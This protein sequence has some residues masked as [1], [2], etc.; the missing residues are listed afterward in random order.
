ME[1]SGEGG[2]GGKKNAVDGTW[3]A[4]G[5]GQKAGR[6]WK[7]TPCKNTYDHFTEALY[8]FLLVLGRIITRI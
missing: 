1:R 6:R 3:K 7:D 8:Y 5:K 4:G 2:G